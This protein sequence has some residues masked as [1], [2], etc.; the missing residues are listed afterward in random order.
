MI[1]RHDSLAFLVLCFTGAA[2]WAADSDL[3]N[4]PSRR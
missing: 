4:A 2:I 1:S 3:E